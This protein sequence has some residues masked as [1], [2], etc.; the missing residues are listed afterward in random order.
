MELSKQFI[1]KYYFVRP[2]MDKFIQ[3]IP[4]NNKC[5]LIK[6]AMYLHHAFILRKTLASD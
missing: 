2:N 5:I 1:E 4:T 3:L 6:L